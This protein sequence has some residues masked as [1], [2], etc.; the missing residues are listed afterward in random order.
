MHLRFFFSS[1]GRNVHGDFEITSLEFLSQ[2]IVKKNHPKLRNKAKGHVFSMSHR[3][4]VGRAHP[5]II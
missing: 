4:I 5:S 1:S 2:G 3:G